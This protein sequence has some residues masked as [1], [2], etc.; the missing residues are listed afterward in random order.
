MKWFFPALILLIAALVF[1]L[2]LLAYAMYALLG[3]ILIS[4]LMTRMWTENL[5]GERRCNRLS[6]N[7]GEQVAVVV[8]VE[9]RGRALVAW[10]YLIETC[11]RGTPWFTA[12]QRSSSL[13]AACNWRC[14][15]AAG[16]R[17]FLTRS[18]ST[19]AATTRSAPWCSRRATCSGFTAA[20]EPPPNQLRARLPRGR[21]P[22]RL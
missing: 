3:A 10:V 9:N 13:A 7:V 17:R 14:C 6:L 12:R 15:V 19:S 16:G 20:G 18:S 5:A 22:G 11:S 21:A 1:D 4:R 2:G 8:S